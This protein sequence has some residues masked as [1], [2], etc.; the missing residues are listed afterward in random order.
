MQLQVHVMRIYLDIKIGIVM[1]DGIR[2]PV[3]LIDMQAEP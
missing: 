3:A 1:R 2:G